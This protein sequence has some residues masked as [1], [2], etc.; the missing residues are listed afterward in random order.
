[1]R[2]YKSNINANNKN[3]LKNYYYYYYYPILN[4][5]YHD[6]RVVGQQN[7]VIGPM[8][9]GTQNICAGETSSNLLD[10]SRLS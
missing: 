6:S 10:Q 2:V 7:T 4:E 5:E 8:R 3:Y 1:M 9:P